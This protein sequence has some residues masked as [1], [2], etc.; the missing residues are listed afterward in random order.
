MCL[1]SQDID[2]KKYHISCN[3]KHLVIYFEAKTNTVD[4]IIFARL[5]FRDFPILG[6][7]PKIRFREISFF[8][9]SSIIIIILYEILDLANL[10][11]SRNSRKLKPREYYQI[12]NNM[13][14]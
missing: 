14:K 11:S 1:V 13:G 2:L 10:S 6:L 8:S 3:R 12:Y 9:S 4:L 5:N 7:F